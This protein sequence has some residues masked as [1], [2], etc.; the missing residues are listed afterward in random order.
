MTNILH[1]NPPA[2]RQGGREYSCSF[3]P[4]PFTNHTPTPDY[5]FSPHEHTDTLKE[6][7]EVSNVIQSS[8]STFTSQWFI[9]ISLQSNSP[10]TIF[11]YSEF[12]CA[13]QIKLGWIILQKLSILFSF[14]IGT[15]LFVTREKYMILKRSPLKGK[16]NSKVL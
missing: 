9:S 7:N 16:T 11:V 10:G 3:T 1:T 13:Y 4:D 2:V 15:Y 12:Y 5:P 14:K 6:E 8:S